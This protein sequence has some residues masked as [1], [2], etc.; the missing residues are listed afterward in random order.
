MPR[1]KIEIPQD[2]LVTFCR[3][4]HIR[5]LA[6]FGSVL[7]DDFQPDSDVDVLVAFEPG[8]VPGLEFFSLEDELSRILGRRVDLNMPGFLG[9]RFRSQALAEAE[10]FYVAP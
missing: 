9:M 7:R 1:T 6:L 2:L 5:Q 4:H 10:V 3:Q 8:F